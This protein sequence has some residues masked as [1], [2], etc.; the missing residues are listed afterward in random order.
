MK[1]LLTEPEKKYIEYK[2][3]LKNNNNHKVIENGLKK[4]SSFSPV[5]YIKIQTP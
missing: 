2:K 1:T 4:L 3:K 5:T